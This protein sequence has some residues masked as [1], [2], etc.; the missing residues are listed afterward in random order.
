[1]A[2]SN[3][4][5]QLQR[6]ISFKMMILILTMIAAL[7]TLYIKASNTSQAKMA[8]SMHV[9]FQGEYKIAD[10][11]W[12][13]I[14][15]GEH[16][17]SRQGNVTLRGYFQLEYPDGSEV[18]GRLSNGSTI[19]FC[20]NHIGVQVKIPGQDTCITDVENPLFGAD[21]CGKKWNSYQYTGTEDDVIEVVLTNQHRFGN[22][23]AVDEFLS[24]IKIYGG[25]N[26]AVFRNEEDSKNNI[27][28]IC[29]I[30][31]LISA[32]IFIGI[33]L[34][35]SRLHISYS[36]YIL[37][38][39]MVAFF[40]GGYTL[41]NIVV[42][43]DAQSVVVFRT[44]AAI[45]CRMLYF[46]CMTHLVP[47]LMEEKERKVAESAAV[48]LDFGTIGML[49]YACLANICLYD[50][51]LPWNFLTAG[52]GILIIVC[53]VSGMRRSDKQGRIVMMMGMIPFL[54]VILDGIAENTGWWRAGLLT[55]YVF[56]ILFLVVWTLVISIIPKNIRSAVREKELQAEQKELKI[57]LR[58]SHVA[59]MISQ[60]QPHFIYNTLGTI[61]YLCHKNPK[62]AADLVQSFA[63]YL[64]GNFSEMDEP[65]P[66]RLNREMEHVRY[67]TDIETVRFPDITVRFDIQ[68]D[69]F[70]VPALTVQPLVE[71]AIKH[72]LM[73]REEG[74]T[75][76]I[77]TY[78]TDTHYCIR[79]EDDGAGFC[80]ADY[81]DEK[82][83]I[84]IRNI[85]GRI[86]A[87]CQG[88][89]TIKSTPGIGTTALVE[90]P[91]GAENS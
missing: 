20:C 70:L 68:S 5:Q 71:N 69:D 83:H 86:E 80:E 47:V 79:V 26:G 1:M 25:D 46:I 30:S 31:L 35:S 15:Q 36:S 52:V 45:L 58:E 17:S 2:E 57:Q 6:R 63:K 65:K 89:L 12:K 13:P 88:T 72:G 59:T 91:K 32:F 28:K 67:Y 60:I 84:G 9:S 18:I 82:T 22:E 53:L 39:G 29:G 37:L 51:N 55:E 23:D 33:A 85:R 4:S 49:M 40:A 14:R 38:M 3:E 76:T 81:K 73:K 27:T 74:G 19:V 75:V 34:F 61:E 24:S 10:G 44:S 64:R 21:A 77:S 87:M 50:L 48:T 41:T 11:P 42:M 66:I 62:M 54:A 7:L 16:I 56:A 78:E 43:P 90:I 8:L